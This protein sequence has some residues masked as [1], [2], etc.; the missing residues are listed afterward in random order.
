MTSEYVPIAFIYNG[1]VKEKSDIPFWRRQS[2]T[3]AAS[4]AGAALVGGVMIAY[5]E[6]TESTSGSVEMVGVAIYKVSDE[7]PVLAR[8]LGSSASG[9]MQDY[10]SLRTRPLHDLRDMQK[11]L[12]AS[13]SECRVVLRPGEGNH[14]NGPTEEFLRHIM[15]GD[16]V[17]GRRH[18]EFKDTPGRD[19]CSWHTQGRLAE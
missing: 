1:M 19:Y 6:L 15:P 18:I 17:E 3:I 4:I 8:C 14:C 2:F 10:A 9:N 7:T 13:D 11:E 12:E 5:S 16:I